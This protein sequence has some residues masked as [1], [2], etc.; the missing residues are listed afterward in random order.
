MKRGVF[1]GQTFFIYLLIRIFLRKFH[2]HAS[3][4]SDDLSGQENILQP[5]GYDLVP[6]F[7]FAYR[8]LGSISVQK[9][10]HAK[11]PCDACTY[12]RFSSFN[13]T[14]SDPST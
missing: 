7:R 12:E 14:C 9:T 10:Y 4:R 13:K 11:I 5:E 2:H 6:V 8:L 1:S 3:G